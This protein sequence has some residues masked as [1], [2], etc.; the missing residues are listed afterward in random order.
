MIQIANWIL[1]RKCN[2]RCD[3]CAIVKN[4]PNKP[5]EY[6]PIEY[7][8]K[9]EMTAEE[10]ITGLKILKQHNPNMF[11]LFYGG[12]PFLKEGLEDIISFCNNNDIEYTVISNCTEQ[13]QP[14]IQ[15]LVKNSGG[16]K[17]FTA[18]IDFVNF[19][20][21][22]KT[23]SIVKSQNAIQVLKSLKGVVKDLVA[24]ITVTKE[25]ENDIFNIV[26]YLS[27]LN[28][29]SDITFVDIA[30]TR[31]YDFS[32]VT[33]EN[34]LV[35]RSAKL[36]EQFQKLVDSN[37]LIHMKRELLIKIWHI[38]PSNMDCKID[39]DLHNITIDADGTIRL[40]LRIRGTSVP[41]L[42]H[43]NNLLLPGGTISPI[44]YSAIRTDK[45]E[46]CKLCNHTCHLMSMISSKDKVAVNNLI[47]RDR[48]S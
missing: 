25:N 30:K 12:E 11:H 42:I 26:E 35:S 40:C 2:L 9:H 5:S 4:T 16:L 22:T 10:I 1:T 3:Y 24:E 21:M 43:I 13:V 41:K 18:S 19:S 28:I 36:A 15:K 46:L 27:S 31:Y 34:Q 45:K 17:G 23:D 37:F 44:T 47:H 8:L 6:P 32:N 38:L 39:Q 48:R 20:N 33:D 14:L 7:Y 29:V